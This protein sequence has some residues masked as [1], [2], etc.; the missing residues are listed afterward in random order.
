MR[1][2]A[3]VNLLLSANTHR[4]WDS[5]GRHDCRNQPGS[6][7]HRYSS[8]LCSSFLFLLQNYIKCFLKLRYLRDIIVTVTNLS[9]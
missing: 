8:S 6:G 9:H 3:T 2:L 4:C 1:G 7:L 5:V